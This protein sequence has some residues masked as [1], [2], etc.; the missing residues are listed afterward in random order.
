ML[1]IEASMGCD[2]KILDL[3]LLFSNIYIVLKCVAIFP[4]LS[5]LGNELSHTWGAS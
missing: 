2:F 1:N 4:T 5:F 3:D